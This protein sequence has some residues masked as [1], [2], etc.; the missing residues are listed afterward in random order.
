MSECGCVPIKLYRH[1]NLNFMRFMSQNIFL[2]QIL[3]Q[4][5]TNI[6]NHSQ[7]TGC[8]KT[9]V[10]LDLAHRPQFAHPCTNP[11]TYQTSNS[12]QQGAGASGPR[13]AVLVPDSSL[14]SAPP[15]PQISS[16]FVPGTAQPGLFDSQICT[17]LLD[18]S[19]HYPFHYP[20][21]N[22]PTFQRPDVSMARYLEIQGR[23]T[24]LFSK[25]II[26]SQ[27]ICN[28]QPQVR[29]HPQLWVKLLSESNGAEVT[30]VPCF[31]QTAPSAFYP[32]VLPVTLNSF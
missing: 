3:F 30:L 27:P 7:F 29:K 31:L 24:Y 14:H 18:Q 32:E 12:T 1:R 23:D 6:K 22:E 9:R 15:L 5:F 8:I 26:S 25:K 13:L 17:Q 16:L 28:P 11:S 4:P 10:M 19:Q 21:L 20:C 2:L